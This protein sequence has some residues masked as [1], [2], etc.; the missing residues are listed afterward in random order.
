MASLFYINTQVG[1]DSILLSRKYNLL[2][3]E[4]EEE[5]LIVMQSYFLQTQ[6]NLKKFKIFKQFKYFRITFTLW[7]PFF[8]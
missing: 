8:E 5:I 3:K 2:G 4:K 7:M 6:K 1:S